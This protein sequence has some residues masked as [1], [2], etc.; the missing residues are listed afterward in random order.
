MNNVNNIL[1]F[2]ILGASTLIH[3]QVVLAVQTQIELDS[4]TIQY[5]K[6]NGHYPNT[7][8]ISLSADRT[9]WSKRSLQANSVID[10]KCSNAPYVKIITQKRP[11]IYE[12]E[13]GA[14]YA[15][16]WNASKNRWELRLL[17]HEPN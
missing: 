4:Y 12:V 8:S 7:F 3:P 14:R 5:N 13:C 2:F 10:M 1:P 17:T 6:L 11:L 15:V 16:E 9:N